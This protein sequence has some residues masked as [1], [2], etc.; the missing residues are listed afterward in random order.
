MTPKLGGF[1][2]PAVGSVGF[3]LALVA[4]ALVLEITSYALSRLTDTDAAVTILALVPSILSVY[5]ARADEH[6]Y[7]SQLLSI[8]RSAVFLTAVLTVM[9]AGVVA[10]NADRGWVLLSLAITVVFT[11]LVFIALMYTTVRVWRKQRRVRANSHITQQPG[12]DRGAFA[13]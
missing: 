3:T 10:I 2:V 1:H 6:A 9:S 12:D 7:V 11:A 4:F 5:V 13:I 8:P